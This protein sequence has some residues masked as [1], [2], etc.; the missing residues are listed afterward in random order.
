MLIRVWQEDGKKRAALP[1]E[2][3]DRDDPTQVLRGESRGEGAD[4]NDVL[5][6]EL[7][8]GRDYLLRLGKPVRREVPFK[9]ATEEQQVY[10]DASTRSQLLAPAQ[11]A[12]P[13]ANSSLG[14]ALSGVTNPI[15]QAVSGSIGSQTSDAYTKIIAA[16]GGAV[17][18]YK[19]LAKLSPKDATRQFQLAHTAEVAG[20]SKTAIAAYDRTI[21][22]AP[23]GPYAAAAKKSLKGLK[24]Q[25]KARAATA[26]PTTKHK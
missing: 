3:V 14:K 25:L 22:L 9:T 20:D 7:P 17:E 4:T 15:Q 12:Q 8:R 18:V 2:V 16:Y 19:Q 5:T 10:A 23:D 13:S 21:A 26:T 6:F 1:V 24:A 11:V